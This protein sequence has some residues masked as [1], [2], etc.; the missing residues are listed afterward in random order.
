MANRSALPL[1]KNSGLVSPVFEIKKDQP[2]I[3]KWALDSIWT[4]VQHGL[5]KGYPDNT[6]HPQGKTTRA[7]AV[8][9]I[10]NALNQ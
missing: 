5:M 10:V 9:V 7:E 8:T 4:A 6:I 3:S 2:A 1:A